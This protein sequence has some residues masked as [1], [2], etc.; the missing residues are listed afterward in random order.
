MAKKKI[1]IIALLALMICSF[2]V[3]GAFTL[4]GAQTS[5]YQVTFHSDKGG[6]TDVVQTVAPGEKATAPAE[7]SREGFDVAWYNGDVAYN[8]GQAVESD[9]TL[10]AKWTKS[11]NEL[12][13]SAGNEFVWQFDKNG[14]S[15]QIPYKDGAP[16]PQYGMYDPTNC[17]VD[18]ADGSIF[19]LTPAYFTA[20][21]GN[22]D[23][24]KAIK[25]SFLMDPNKAWS[26]SGVGRFV[27]SL[28]DTYEQITSVGNNAWNP[29][30][31]AKV[32]AWGSLAENEY[33]HKITID[34]SASQELDYTNERAELV[35][36]IGETAQESYAM[37]NNQ[38]ICGLN[39]CR[40][41]FIDGTATLSFMALE[42][43][44]ESKIQISQYDADATVTFKSST[45][46]FIEKSESHMI[47]FTLEEPEA[48]TIDGYTFAGY[49]ED[50]ACAQPF[51]FDSPIMGDTVIYVKYVR[52]GADLVQVTF[53]SETGR[54]EDVV[55][56]V[57]KGT[58]VAEP[59]NLFEK[60]GY[61]ITWMLN[62]EEYDFT[63]AVQDDITLTA[64]WSEDEIV[65]YH[66]M[67]D[68]IDYNYCWEYLQDE[69]GWDEEYTTYDIGDTFV[70]E[71]GNEI[72]SMYYGGYQHDSSFKTYDDYT[73][74][75]LPAV[76]AI[77]N[78]KQL[79]VTKEIRIVYSVNNWDSGN[80][81]NPA[82]G[83][84]T[85]QLFDGLFSALKSGHDNNV[86]ALVAI[87]TSSVESSAIYGKFQDVF[88]NVTSD[89]F[90]FE[91]DKQFVI[92]I[93]I[94]EDGTKN[95]LKVNDTVIEGALAGI[96]QSDFVNGY[97][98]L[99]IA[100]VGSTHMYNCLV[101]QP[102]KLTIET[103][104]HGT[105]Q[106][107]V[108]GE[109]V[110]FKQKVTLTLTPEEGYAAKAVTVGDEVYYAD[111]NNTVVFYKG[112]EDETVVIEFAKAYTMSFETNGGSAVES[113]TVCE[114]DLFYKPSNPKKEG[115]KFVGWYT[116][117]ACT[118]EYDFKQT[119]SS[120]IKLY[121]KWE[122]EEAEQTGCGGS[123]GTPMLLGGTV[124]L[125]SAAAFIF[126][127]KTER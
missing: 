6:F 39:V 92:S 5:G 85:F 52:E 83:R 4:V 62:G 60:E 61:S 88:S 123:I 29:A 69:N 58:P 43:S 107:D 68:V 121:A 36:Y 105:V 51:D 54:F 33:Y 2:F 91:Q 41:D 67:N 126:K 106:A 65:L 82:D 22:L 119:A 110:M 40:N 18:G 117:E 14:V 114:G 90:G 46:G 47:G 95:V 102:S 101:S 124:V 7:I 96:K 81:N 97:A 103:P 115:F 86:G 79:D 98:Y 31:G 72:I 3:C 8:F 116:D 66:K 17:Y 104:E 84:I 37:L 74:F 13:D 94:S 10:T 23:V 25:I 111:A 49:F 100:N 55:T 80:N 28:F 16:V 63:A 56:E 19:V 27:F 38:K 113:Q 15:S 99:H 53:H 42:A 127:K 89:S 64:K 71:D 75:L 73:S 50:E 11:A 122:A 78:L 30:Y 120:D 108:S 118:K 57:E 21:G 93:Y 34:S 59:S 87:A 26:G 76:G 109:D 9:L 12:K 70:D 48:Q 20:L 45:P 24:T 112:W 77:T 125:L 44:L 1:A 35:L 32:I